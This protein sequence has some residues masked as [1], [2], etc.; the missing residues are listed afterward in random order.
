MGSGTF[1]NSPKTV[2]QDIFS[3][4][5]IS[6]QD[7][8]LLHLFPLILHLQPTTMRHK[9][10]QELEQQFQKQ[11]EELRG[12]L[13]AKLPKDG[14]SNFSV[15][16]A[17]DSLDPLLARY[18]LLYQATPKCLAKEI[19]REPEQQ[20]LI[21]Q[22][23]SDDGDTA[24]LK[25]M[26][27]ADGPRN[28]KWGRAL[29]IYHDI[30][31]ISEHLKASD[32]HP[33]LQRLALAVALE[34]AQPIEQDNPK[35]PDHE[36]DSHV[37]P[38]RR[39][40]NYEMAFVQGD[41]DPHFEL[42]KT[43]ELRFVVDGTEP[44]EVAQWG[45]E[46]LRNYRPDHVLT[47]NRDWRYVEMV[48][49]NI[50]YG[51]GDVKYDRDD[52][53]LYQ[54]ILLN[55]GVCGRRAFFGRFVLRAFGI[56]T[57]ARPSK[58]HGALCH[59]T[60]LEKN[61]KDECFGGWCVCL[62]GG[63]GAG[64]TKT[65]YK[66][67]LDFLAT[68][69]ARA[70]TQ[71]YWKVK[72]AQ[73]IG[74]VFQEK[75]YYGEKQIEEDKNAN[76]GFWFE[77]SLKVQKEILEG[78]GSLKSLP[79]CKQKRTHKP[80]IA[81]Q[82]LA[83]MVTANDKQICYNSPDEPGSIVIPSAAFCSPKKSSK[84]VVVMTSFH[85]ISGGLQVYLP[86]FPSQGLTIVRGGTWKCDPDGCCS[87]TRLK[88]GGY[89]K[90]EDWGLRVAMSGPED[91]ST[92]NQ[93]EIS[94]DLNVEGT[95]KMDFVFCPP[96][97]FIMGGDPNKKDG[98]FECSETPKH[99]VTLTRGFWLGKYPVTQEQYQTIMGNNPSKSTKD[100]KCPVDNIGVSEAFDYVDKMMEVIG[101]DFRL[102]TE[103][104][105]EYAARGGRGDQK[106]FFGNDPKAL[107]EYA[108]F[109][110]NS[111]GKS[112]P[113]GQKK[114]NPFGLCDIYGQVYERVS[115]KY[116]VDYYKISPK[117][118]PTGPSQGTKSI[119]E[120]KV[121]VPAAC[122]YNLEAEVVTANFKQHL[123]VIV[124]GDES[125]EQQLDLPWTNGFWAD[126]TSPCVLSLQAGENT[127]RFWRDNPPQYGVAVKSFT[128]SPRL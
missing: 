21:Q 125:S 5:K 84:D 100:P 114:P 79:Q 107:G 71:A 34:H 45:R 63:W 128:L 96:G 93:R 12:K 55:G 25:D 98:R 77:A 35:K 56:P 111:G 3:R 120:Y 64:W 15:I 70:D 49:S 6:I 27:L 2:I 53:Q 73:W 18:V 36:L 17:S 28:Y 72:R 66:P 105:W 78:L 20:V 123:K 32:T 13:Q 44:D 81:E 69:K 99:K 11:L 14:E 61:D 47:P 24:L 29:Q 121:K 37:D 9:P 75:P 116:A 42:L 67:D 43:W 39:Y 89:G 31:D 109:K 87:G 65:Q 38:I 41:L 94:V 59:W 54:N 112:H 88:S 58:G 30:C 51:S 113:V 7:F 127:L 110:G 80:T 104:E 101:R 26:L 4:N 95:V 90:Y 19:A 92:P 86:S 97:T 50:R 22:I 122:K 126:T 46:M 74:G 115:D 106:W 118:D 10:E 1:S 48:R 82:V 85:P 103:A 119:V 52:L 108:W 57:T 60:P 91:G 16:V 83:R 102:P 76:V 68:S 8:L 23:L 40:L 33:V 124:N 117:K 62:G